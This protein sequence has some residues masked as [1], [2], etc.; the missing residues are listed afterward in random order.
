MLKK[1]LLITLI[2]LV[3]LALAACESGTQESADKTVE[4]TKEAVEAA[5]ETVEKAAED[6]KEA[7]KE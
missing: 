1:P 6:V 2:A 7:V 5:G 4:E 3:A